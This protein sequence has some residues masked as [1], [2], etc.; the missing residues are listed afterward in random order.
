MDV[1]GAGR[2]QGHIKTDIGK[3]ILYSFSFLLRPI[4]FIFFLIAGPGWGIPRI[5][6]NVIMMNI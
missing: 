2:L 4:S 3:S 1:V 6:S 5:I